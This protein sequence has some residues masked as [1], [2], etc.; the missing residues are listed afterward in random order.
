MEA[1]SGNQTLFDDLLVGE[2][3][4]V[5][6]EDEL[7]ARF[8]LALHHGLISG[9]VHIEGQNFVGTPLRPDP[10][11]VNATHVA[12]K[13]RSWSWTVLSGTSAEDATGATIRLSFSAERESLVSPRD[14]DS[15]LPA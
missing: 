8:M 1:L 10:E 2:I 14:L 5:T 4:K 9:D 13:P 3:M 12:F 7:S 15:P 6:G 11:I